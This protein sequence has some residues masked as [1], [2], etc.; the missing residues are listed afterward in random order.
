LGNA[1]PV[2]TVDR[3]CSDSELWL[4]RL[5]DRLYFLPV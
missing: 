4:Y 2:K 5:L 3:T 1:L